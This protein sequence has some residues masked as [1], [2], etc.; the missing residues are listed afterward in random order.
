M[1]FVVVVFLGGSFTFGC[2]SEFRYI[3]LGGKIILPLDASGILTKARSKSKEPPLLGAREGA[4][5]YEKVRR[6]GK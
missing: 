1:L 4:S 6:H 2:Q 5:K 3:F